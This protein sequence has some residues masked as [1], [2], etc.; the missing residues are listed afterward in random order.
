MPFTEKLTPRTEIIWFFEFK[1]K[2]LICK[3]APFRIP[4]EVQFYIFT[5]LNYLKKKKSN[6]RQ[7]LVPDY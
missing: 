6:I 1:M 4:P 3:Y 5:L 7:L 2:N